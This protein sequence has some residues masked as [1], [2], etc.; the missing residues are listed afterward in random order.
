[1]FYNLTDLPY[2]R[3]PL[4][5]LGF[6]IAYFS[7]G[8]IVIVVLGYV[9][10]LIGIIESYDDGFAVG[11]IGAILIST[12]LAYFVAKSKYLLGSFLIIFLIILSGLLAIIGGLLLGLIPVAYI[13][14]K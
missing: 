9:L 12:L 10:A 6:Y 8:L 3:T 2:R 4:Q 11:N 13:T 7:I 14:T 1:M 5:A